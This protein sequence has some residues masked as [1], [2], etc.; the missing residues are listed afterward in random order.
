MTDTPSGSPVSFA[1]IDMFAGNPDGDI[2]VSKNYAN[3]TDEHV[4]G[5]QIRFEEVD[6]FDWTERVN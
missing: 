4:Q 1:E 2:I 3:G 6:P 5:F